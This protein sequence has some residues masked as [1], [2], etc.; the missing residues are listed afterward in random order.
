[1]WTNKME[2]KRKVMQYE[3]KGCYWL[4]KTKNDTGYRLCFKHIDKS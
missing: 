4:E 1:M 2:T 3:T